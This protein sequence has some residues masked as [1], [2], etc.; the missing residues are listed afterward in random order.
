MTDPDS[1]Y[2]EIFG[3]R[4]ENWREPLGALRLTLS[5]ENPQPWDWE[6]A[7]EECEWLVR[8]L[9]GVDE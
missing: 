7:R 5:A 6:R 4:P 9:N 1:D 2:I 3:R 8:V